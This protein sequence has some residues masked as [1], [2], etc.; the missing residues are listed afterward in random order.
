MENEKNGSTTGVHIHDIV[1]VSNYQKTNPDGTKA[2]YSFYEK[3]Q[4]GLVVQVNEEKMVCK[5]PNG[6]DEVYTVNEEQKEYYKR[7]GKGSEVEYEREI[8]KTIEKLIKERQEKDD[9]I[10]ELTTWLYDFKHTISFLGKM[11]R[12]IKEF[13]R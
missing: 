12:F 2:G 4:V 6:E 8:K 9:K 7:I 5:L 11:S 1:V 10:K 13:S 3:D